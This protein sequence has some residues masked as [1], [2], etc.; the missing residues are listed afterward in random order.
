MQR[1]IQRKIRCAVWT[2]TPFLLA[3]LIAAS[4]GCGNTVTVVSGAGGSA[5][6]GDADNAGGLAVGGSTAGGAAFVGGSSGDPTGQGGTGMGDCYVGH[7]NC[8][9]ACY[10]V[11]CCAPDRDLKAECLERCAASVYVPSHEIHCLALR[12]FWLDE[13]G[14]ESIVSTY[15]NFELDDDCSGE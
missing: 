3:V 11:D 14:C 8:A 2:G 5:G 15:D 4:G 12:V 1:H 10:L 13:E 9:D 7:A 6:S